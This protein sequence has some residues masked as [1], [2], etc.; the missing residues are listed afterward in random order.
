[1]TSN[2]LFK[3]IFNSINDIIDGTYLP[4]E[5]NRSDADKAVAENRARVAKYTNEDFEDDDKLNE[6]LDETDAM[7]DEFD[8]LEPMARAI[9][10]LCFDGDFKS[11]IIEMQDKAIDAN[12]EAKH[13]AKSCKC[14]TK[15]EDC[16]CETRCELLKCD[17]DC[18][19]EKSSTTAELA[20][21]YMEEVVKPTYKK[22]YGEYDEKKYKQAEKAFKQFA[23]WVLEQ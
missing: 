19:C 3:E 11:K 18:D 2:E 15:C 23:D 5:D 10:N 16:K 7:L 17:E 9:I 4:K 1:M 13:K 6:F 8:E 20:H 14:A 12:C 21:R 22:Y